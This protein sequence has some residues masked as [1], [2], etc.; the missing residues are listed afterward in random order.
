MIIRIPKKYADNF[1]NHAHKQIRK[2]FYEE[3]LFNFYKKT[4]KFHIRL[5]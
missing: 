5:N 4:N 1:E 2:R 3:N